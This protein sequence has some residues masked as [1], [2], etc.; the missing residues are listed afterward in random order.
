M[1]DFEGAFKLLNNFLFFGNKHYR[2]HISPVSGAVF[3]WYRNNGF[4]SSAFLVG[5]N[6]SMRYPLKSK[7]NLWKSDSVLKKP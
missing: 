4:G 5:Y 2:I 6:P 7:V 3:E 1:L